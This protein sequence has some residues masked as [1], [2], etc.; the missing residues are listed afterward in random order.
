MLLLRRWTCLILV[1]LMLL[2]M[3]PVSALATDL[4]QESEAAVEQVSEEETPVETAQPEE[5]TE[6][7]EATESVETVEPV[8]AAAEA[9]AEEEILPLTEEE[10]PAFDLARLAKLELRTLPKKTTYQVGAALNLTGIGVYAEDEQGASQILGAENLTVLSGDTSAAGIRKITVGVGNLQVSFDVIVHTLHK[11]GEFLQD[12]EDYPESDHNYSNYADEDYT[13]TCPGAEYLKLTFSQNTQ[14]ES[15]C[16]WLYIYDGKE[17]LLE[18]YTGNALAGQTITIQGDTVVLNLTSDGSATRYGFSLDAVYAYV[19]VPIHEAGKNSVY[20]DPLCFVDAYTTHTCWICGE[21][22]AEEH[23]DTAAHV[24]DGGFCQICG[25]PQN[26]TAQGKLNDTIAWA[27]TQENVLYLAGSGATPDNVSWDTSLL[28]AVTTL[29]V[30]N[31]ITRLGDGLF[32]GCTGIQEVQLPDTLEEIGNNVFYGCTGLTQVQLPKNLKSIGNNV[33]YGCTGLTSLT[34]NAGL[35]SIGSNAL[36][37]CKA[38]TMLYIPGSVVTITAGG[39]SSSPFYGCSSNL[40]IYCQ[41]IE[42]QEGWGAYW[43]Y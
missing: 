38:L 8:E 31:G 24:I 10:S 4:P 1:F 36:R 7:T 41:A 30:G 26:A 35:E 5:V 32:T 12:S 18:S 9:E 43:N 13:Y 29:V 17:N 37:N 34:L 39:Y 42:K 22:W 15:N 25:L 40:A 27:I 19:D 2:G 20:T 16:D 33:F 23:P 3:L 11:K 28:S 14:F 21:T 6:P